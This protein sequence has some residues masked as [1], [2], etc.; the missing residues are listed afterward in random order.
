MFE[1][2]ESRERRARDNAEIAS[3]FRQYGEDTIPTLMRRAENSAA[4][5][6]TRKHWER[7]IKKAQRMEHSD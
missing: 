4:G 2:F 1:F 5:S 6:R 3:L 7:L